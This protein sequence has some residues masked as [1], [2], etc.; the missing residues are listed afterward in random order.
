MR[1]RNVFMGYLGK[2][3]STWDVFDHDGFFHSGD[4]GRID[5]DG[6]IRLTGRIKDLIITSGGE[7]VAP[8]QLELDLKSTCEF[9]SNAMIVGE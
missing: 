3:K 4:Q 8:S 6:F 5:S 1:G 9:L 2:E 7:N